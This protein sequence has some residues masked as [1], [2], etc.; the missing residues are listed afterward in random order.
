MME[1]V[2]WGPGSKSM[3]GLGHGKEKLRNGRR[4]GETEG[5]TG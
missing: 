3:L 1:R 5:D 4:G 2:S